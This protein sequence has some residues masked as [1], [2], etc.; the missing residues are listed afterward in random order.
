M[1]KQGVWL[2]RILPDGTYGYGS[3][4][5]S[6]MWGVPLYNGALLYMAGLP[7][8]IVFKLLLLIPNLLSGIAFFAW[9][10][11]KVGK[12]ASGV[13]TIVYIWAP[14]RFLDTFIRYSVG[15]LYFFALL[16]CLLYFLDQANSKKSI[17]FG[18]ISAAAMIYSHQGLSFIAYPLCLGYCFIGY[19]T[20]RKKD[21]F[22]RQLLLLGN[23]LL[24]SSFYWIPVLF[25][26]QL[27]D[28]HPDR[29]ETQWFPPL[30][31][32]VR[33]KWEGGS[34]FNGQTLI[35]SF[36]IGLVQIAILFLAH[37]AAIYSFFRKKAVP[38]LL[39]YW[40]GVF[41][42]GLFLLQPISEW[43][44]MN[45][46][47]LAHL[48]FPFR[49]LFIPML[50]AAICCGYLLRS[51]SSFWQYT[52]GILLILAVMVTNRNHLGVLNKSI[53]VPEIA[54][55]EGTYFVGG[56]MQAYDADFKKIEADETA[57]VP[58]QEFQILQ[59]TG[60][61]TG[62]KREL[63]KSTATIIMDTPGEVAI[64]R[65]NFP[66]W[67][68]TRNTIPVKSSKPSVLQVSLPV[69]T[70]EIAVA[71]SDP[72]FVK[73]ATAIT[74]TTFVAN[75]WI[76]LFSQHKQKIASRKNTGAV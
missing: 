29:I 61:I 22:I 33:S 9:M 60:K 13:A 18:G 55:Y 66:G 58:R 64:R 17:F 72:I 21:V 50:T 34:V 76:I 46:P 48:Q 38:L 24:L 41:W 2:P 35:M 54:A 10:K 45:L 59:G 12:I 74:I 70:S 32:L 1:I 31:S 44:W 73:S 65:L 3:P 15:E 53:T 40:L 75:I 6:F 26:V 23:G 42:I 36:Q 20:T 71:Y 19:M 39:F 4:V 16:P 5:F 37:I 67:N 11:P 56:E 27:L 28:I 69:G 14:Y 43:F 30:L 52:A 47:L 63:Y 7:Y 25:Y 51:L 57:N 68:I 49:L 62:E 8:P